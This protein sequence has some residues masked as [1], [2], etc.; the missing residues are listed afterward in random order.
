MGVFT[1]Q[2]PGIGIFQLTTAEEAFLTSFANLSYS[3]GQVLTIVSGSPAWANPSGGVPTSARIWEIP[4][5]NATEDGYMTSDAFLFEDQ[6]EQLQISSRNPNGIGAANFTIED[7]FRVMEFHNSGLDAHAGYFVTDDFS[8]G[9]SGVDSFVGSF[10][11]D[12]NGFAVKYDGS[13]D[14]AWGYV[15]YKQADGF[16]YDP[17]YPINFQDSLYFA[18]ETYAQHVNGWASASPSMV[19]GTGAGTSPTSSIQGT[20]TGMRIVITTGT[21]PATNAT[22]ATVTFNRPYAIRPFVVFSAE[23]QRRLL[24]Q[25]QYILMHQ[26]EILLQLK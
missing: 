15:L 2:N 10:G 8:T 11:S 9:T 6:E 18:G 24:V 16:I 23:M 25:Q 22:V 26:M 17:L 20:D 12:R 3:N 1:V 14:A 19:L 4:F 13:D 5:V 21:T 7:G